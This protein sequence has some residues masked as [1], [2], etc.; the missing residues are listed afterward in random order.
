MKKKLL[1][2]RVKR[3]IEAEA[4][5][6]EEKVKG[7]EEIG[8]SSDLYARILK[9]ARESSSKSR[10]LIRIFKKT[11]LA[12]TAVVV[13]GTA[14][15]ICTSGAKLFVP[16]VEKRGDGERVNVSINNDDADYVELTEDEA[17]EEIEER[18][19]ILA[20]RLR[21]KPKGMELKTVCI[22]ED[23]GEALLE[24]YQDEY[25]LTVYENKQND[26]AS[27]NVQSD[28]QVVDQIEQFYLGDEVEIIEIQD[29]DNRIRYQTQIEYGNAY[30]YLTTNME[31]KEFENII[32][33]LIFKNV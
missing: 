14:A 26:G 13:L 2:E 12:V 22:S 1:R 28:G 3:E 31:L 8:P 4:D 27:I 20:L 5:A 32:Q 19:G 11:L 25:I 9:D 21:Y 23:M 10:K 7:K 30:Y 17:Y 29:T 15:S 33:G 18:L 16:W 24:F 6:L